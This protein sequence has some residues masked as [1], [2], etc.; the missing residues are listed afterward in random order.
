MRTIMISDQAYEKLASMK[1]DKSFTEL[2]TELAERVR[3][4][5]KSSILKFAGIMDK[6]EAEE[7]QGEIKEIRKRFGARP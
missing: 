2:L 4:T 6:D 5:S 3:Q 7:L 1:G